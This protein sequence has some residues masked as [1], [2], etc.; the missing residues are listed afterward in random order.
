MS[1]TGSATDAGARPAAVP[2]ASAVLAALLTLGAFAVGIAALWRSYL[3]FR[4]A[5][6]HDVQ[7]QV[8]ADR[9]TH[10]DEVLTMS[11]RMAAATGEPSW[12]ARYL[13]FEPQLDAAIAQAQTLAPDLFAGEATAQTDAA[14]RAL[15]AMEQRAFE[16]VRQGRRSEAAAVL[17]AG[18]Y[19]RQKRIYAEG[20]AATVAAVASRLETNSDRLRRE[21]VWGAVLLTAI[22]P[23]AV[24]AWVRV[25]RGFRRYAGALDAA[26]TELRRRRDELEE[27]VAERTAQ[28]GS[29]NLAL[30]AEAGQRRRAEEALI[31]RERMFRSL[32]ENASDNIT[33]LASDGVTRYESPALEPM[34]G[35]KPD[36][37]VGRNTFELVHPEDLPAAQAALA[38]VL[39]SPGAVR[40]VEVR[41][42]HKDGRWLHLEARGKAVPDGAGGLEVIVNSHDVSQR[43]ALERSRELLAAIL[44]AGSDF[45]G[46]ADAGGRPL[47]LNRAGRRMVGLPD[48]ADVTVTHIRDYHPPA[49]MELMTTTAFPTAVREGCWQGESAV[50][51]RDGREIP[52]SQVVI[53]HRTPDG[54]VDRFSTIIRDI[55]GRKR[56]EQA[57]RENEERF[58]GAFDNAPI[59]MA[60]V[61][62]DGRFLRVNP[63]LCRLLEYSA[64]ELLGR[65]F[66]SITHP[67]DVTT[68]L[69]GARRLLAG[70]IPFYEAEKR[71][72][73]KSGEPVWALLNVS[74]V[75]DACGGPLH[76]ISQIQD[77]TERRRAEQ[78]I[79][80]AKAA[81][82]AASVAKS[83]FLANMSHEIR[84][85]MNGI[86]GMTELALETELSEQQREYLEIVRSSADAL[87]T[88]INDILDFSKIEAGKMTLDP[89]EFR[90]RRAAADVARLFAV[91]AEQKGIEI[92]CDIAPDVPEDLVG[93]VGRLRQ[94]LVNLVGNALK[95]TDQGEI[96]LSIRAESLGDAEAVLCFSV[97][98][99][100]IGISPE[101]QERIFRPF[102]QADTSTTRRYGGTGLGLTISRQLVEMMHGR[103]WVESSPGAGSTFHFTVRMGV[104]RERS[105]RR[106]TRRSQRMTDLPVLI[107]DDNAANRRV[108][109]HTVAN[110]GA[111]PTAVDSAAAALEIIDKARRDNNPFALVILDAVMPG[112]DGFTLAEKL[113]GDPAGSEAPLMMLSSAGSAEDA[114]RCRSLGMSAYLTKPVTPA[115]LWDAVS[116]V[117]GTSSD[118]MPAPL[119]TRQTI[120]ARRPLNFLLAEDNPVNRR[121]AAHLLEKRGHKVTSADNGRKAVELFGAERFDAVLMDIQMPEMDGLEAARAIRALERGGDRRTPIIAMTA[122]AMSGDRER[123]LS[124]GMDAYVT[125]PVSQREL[126]AAVDALVESPADA[127]TA[128]PAAVS[129]SADRPDASAAPVEAAVDRGALLARLD[130]NT[131]LLRELVRLFCEDGPRQIA[132]LEEAAADRDP[133]GLARAAHTIKGAVAVFCAKSAAEAAA[134]VEKAARVGDVTRAAAS[135]DALKQHVERVRR[136]LTDMTARV[137]ETA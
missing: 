56:A 121:L 99:T 47:Y 115:E 64:E 81:A 117:L 125:K 36:E 37:L 6:E 123:C 85:P 8:L 51:H 49:V 29:S 13:E 109:Q 7:L 105:V 113:K 28:L 114:T 52:V 30:E 40:S 15:V 22:L 91:R 18:E 77:I 79:R 134:A 62:P 65:D 61:A 101:Q 132:A 104:A 120:A 73:R 70:E 95:F 78:A 110:W 137:Q 44:E 50:L 129:E 25:L 57:M 106:G 17:A 131:E 16:L 71:Y 88:V 35:Y 26:Q 32:I 118:D 43:K 90:L 41:Y 130:G 14:N 60:M 68:N 21:A 2:R 58:R 102:T 69:A 24:L 12:E 135:V 89:V 54:R 10:L 1:A 107:V 133:T 108:L 48:D 67:E 83:R 112:M 55:S 98:D 93:D 45:V 116:T 97:R 23:A 4:Q 11:A 33:I 119:V 92:V 9:I 84:T 82:E 126:F 103:M 66:A 111:R 75:R 74:L 53:A 42:R 96:V 87:L 136:D 127:D 34:L 128:E 39:A 27:R 46:I 94:I 19:A 5:V 59:G 80:E 20:V 124:A 100:G 38:E 76:F 31:A 122:H 72:I 3:N 63:A 86:L